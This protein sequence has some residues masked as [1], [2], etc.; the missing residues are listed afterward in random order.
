[1]TTDVDPV[2]P[3]DPIDPVVEVVDGVLVVG[4]EA[5]AVAYAETTIATAVSMLHG[6]VLELGLGMG[7]T[8]DA[9]LE[10]GVQSVATVEVSGAVV[11]HYEGDTDGVVQ[12][13]ATAYLQAATP[14]S[15]DSALVDLP[16]EDVASPAFHAAL[17]TAL[18]ALGTR[19][20]VISAAPALALP[21]FA[22]GLV[23]PTEDG[24]WV[25]TFDRFDPDAGIGERNPHG[26]NYLPGYGWQT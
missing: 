4:G 24:L 23:T 10:A 6:R 25:L 12:A 8:R 3:V 18:P 17:K 2:D 26:D 9:L 16:A 11:D 15:W 1:M 19:V 20:V 21:G 22:L 5:V 14:G 13:E 7:Q